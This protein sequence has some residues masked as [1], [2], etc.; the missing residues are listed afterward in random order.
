MPRDKTCDDSRNEGDQVHRAIKRHDYS[1]IAGMLEAGLDPNRGYGYHCD[2]TPLM[3]AAQEGDTP[4]CELLLSAG[5]DPDVAGHF[6]EAALAVAA[7]AGQRKVVSLLLDRGANPRG[8]LPGHEVLLGPA[9]NGGSDPR[10]AARIMVMLEEAIEDHPDAGTREFHRWWELLLGCLAPEASLD[11]QATQAERSFESIGPEKRGLVLDGLMSL[12]IRRA[13]GWELAARILE[14][15]VRPSDLDILQKV[16][17]AA[18]ATAGRYDD[19]NDIALLRVLAA[20]PHHRPGLPWIVHFFFYRPL[21]VAALVRCCTSAAWWRAFSQ[22]L[23]EDS[24]RLKW[25]AEQRSVILEALSAAGC[26]NG[27]SAGPDVLSAAA[28]RE[29]VP[30]SNRGLKG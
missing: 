10:T 21:A 14:R 20:H 23:I 24:A 8:G 28:S 5:A 17:A 7:L 13:A 6:R 11:D 26:V 12:V 22:A 16:A 30:G 25:P 2:F 9:Y 19:P 15:R 3:Y 29:D 1:R 27:Q 18:F 4:I